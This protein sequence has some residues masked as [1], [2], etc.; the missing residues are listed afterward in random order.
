MKL[1]FALESWYPLTHGGLGA[2]RVLGAQAPATAFEVRDAW[3][4]CGPDEVLVLV[5]SG[6]ASLAR[7]LTRRRGRRSLAATLAPELSL[8]GQVERWRVLPGTGGSHVLMPSLCG[9]LE[10]GLPLLPA[11]RRRWRLARRVLLV[12]ERLGLGDRV[13]FGELLV[14]VKGRRST[15]PG[16]TWLA[17]RPAA[18]SAIALG[19]P[20]L[21]RKATLRVCDPGGA[22]QGF[23]KL[24]LTDAAR[25]RVLHEAET[26]ERVAQLAPTSALAPRL[27]ARGETQDSAWLVQSP[28]PGGR[29]ADHLS[30]VH[31]T[32]LVQ[33]ARLGAHSVSRADLGALPAARERIDEL[34]GRVEPDWVLAMQGLAHALSSALGQHEVP[35]GPA[36]GDFTPW[37]LAQD[38]ERLAAFDWEFADWSAPVLSDLVHFHLQT[39]ILV[40]RAAAPLLLAELEALVRGPARRL[41][42][43]RGL[44]TTDAL[45]FIGLEVLRAA[46]ADELLNSIERPPFAQV[47]WLRSTRVELARLLAGRLLAAGRAPA[48]RA[49]AA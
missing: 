38:G 7:A 11:G 1:P 32:Y 33:L 25:S 20:G 12:A 10:S 37:N 5:D 15:S 2:P 28:L 29:S 22:A 44:E 14:A 48:G 3:R 21:L 8:Q 9:G 26:L 49:S 6:P 17:Q 24:S 30:E 43:E 31:V 39:G 35:C 18:L 42:V 46:T 23:L 47:E 19:V 27:L 13:G 36:H 45:T 34:R 41:L 16:C 40:R 4:Q